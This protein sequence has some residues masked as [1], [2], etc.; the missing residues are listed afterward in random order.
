MDH[1]MEEIG[2][3]NND[4][5]VKLNI[6]CSEI[7]KISEENKL[8]KEKTDS[9]FNEILSLK[10]SPHPNP[11]LDNR[12]HRL[13]S[14]IIDGLVKR[15][16]LDNKDVSRGSNKDEVLAT[17]RPGR[18][19]H[20]PPPVTSSSPKDQGVR[21]KVVE[22]KDHDSGIDTSGPFLSAH[23]GLAVGDTLPL[24]DEDNISKPHMSNRK[25]M[26]Q[27]KDQYFHPKQDLTKIPSTAHT[28]CSGLNDV[29]IKPSK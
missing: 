19:R 3:I 29:K 1:K 16:Y 8:L 11:R 22:N 4:L 13:N 17:T 10:Y 5:N 24:P 21:A 20:R 28:V 18:C 27:D 12:L 23:C 7:S 6:K 25:S 15:R 26:G 9:Q 14:E 2:H